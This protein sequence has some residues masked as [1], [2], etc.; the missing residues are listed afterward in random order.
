MYLPIGG[1]VDE[2]VYVFWILVGVMDLSMEFI[3]FLVMA[4]VEFFFRVIINKKSFLRNPLRVD[5][6]GSVTLLENLCE[7]RLWCL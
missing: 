2:Y 3:I 7:L 1:V 6:L 5:Q 4:L